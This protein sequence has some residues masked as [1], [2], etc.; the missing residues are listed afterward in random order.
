MRALVPDWMPEDPAPA[1]G[2]KRSKKMME[3]RA[4]ARGGGERRIQG[5]VNCMD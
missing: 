4:P 1:G 5:Y 3:E 2:G